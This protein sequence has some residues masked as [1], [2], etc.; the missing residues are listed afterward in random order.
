MSDDD[1]GP[2]ADHGAFRYLVEALRA[3]GVRVGAQTDV[4]E[5]TA[6]FFESA[7]FPAWIKAVAKDGSVNLLR[8]NKACERVM[9][10]ATQDYALKTDIDIYG[11]QGAQDAAASDRLAI[12]MGEPQRV[13]NVA[14]NMLTGVRTRLVGW[15]WTVPLHSPAVAICGFGLEYPA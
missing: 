5:M 11:E 9:G 14:V 10:V 13:E 4:L 1:A 12:I 8:I 7:P 15:K 3:T 6:A 2:A